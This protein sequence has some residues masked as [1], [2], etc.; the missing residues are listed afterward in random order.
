MPDDTPCAVM[1][2]N[3]WQTP[4]DGEAVAR[5]AGTPGNH[6]RSVGKA[7]A[8]NTLQGLSKVVAGAARYRKNHHK[9]KSRPRMAF[10]GPVGPVGG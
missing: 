4:M 10:M 3:R 9:D 6:R 1:R 2:A 7:G 8:A 5:L